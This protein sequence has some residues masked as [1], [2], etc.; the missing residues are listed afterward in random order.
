[1]VAPNDIIKL[2][3]RAFWDVDMSK[4]DYEKQAN[5]ITRKVFENGSWDD[6]LEITAFYGLGKVKDILTAATYLKENTLYFASLF[7]DIPRSQFACYTTTQY[8]P[9]R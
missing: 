1:M 7:L 9:V 5:Y 4:L 8:H 2:S 3:G 6:I